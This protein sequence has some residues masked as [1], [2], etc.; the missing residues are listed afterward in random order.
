MASWREMER[1]RRSPVEFRTIAQRLLDRAGE[2][3]STWE[4]GFLEDVTLKSYVT[5]YS[6]RQTEKLLQVKNALTPIEVV[7]GFSV[8]ILLKRCFDARNDL[9]E[10]DEE[11]IAALRARR[12]TTILGSE[13]GRLLRC[14]RQLNL[15]DTENE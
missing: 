6:L 4:V 1:L 7:R 5:E 13:A 3:A 2:A 11:W 10:S 14:A 9:S 15:I 8:A 12:T